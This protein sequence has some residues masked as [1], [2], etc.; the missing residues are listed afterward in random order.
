MSEVAF[1]NDVLQTIFGRPLDKAEKTRYKQRIRRGLPQIKLGEARIPFG[2]GRQGQKSHTIRKADVPVLR[3]FLRDF[4]SEILH[5]MPDLDS[6]ITPVAP[7]PSVL[8]PSEVL[9]S[10]EQ[11][12]YVWHVS[13]DEKGIYNIGSSRTSAQ[14]RIKAKMTARTGKAVFDLEI[15]CDDCAGLERR[16]HDVL[17]LRKKQLSKEVFKTSIDEVKSIYQF[18][19]QS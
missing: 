12:V 11:F 8:S 5:S 9:G 14:S 7:G 4:D 10:G 3:K 16:I 1:L 2:K 6:D 19:Y 13:T 18:L 17:T 15:R